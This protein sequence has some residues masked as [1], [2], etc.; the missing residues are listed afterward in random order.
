MPSIM[1]RSVKPLA[2]GLVAPVVLISVCGIFSAVGSGALALTNTFYLYLYCTLRG[3]SVVRS[4]KQYRVK[5]LFQYLLK[6]WLLF[7]S[8]FQLEMGLPCL[9]LSGSCA[10]AGRNKM[11]SVKGAASANSFITLTIA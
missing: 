10:N 6:H 4:P 2:P 7:V 5:A 8:R 3:Q 1:P 11:I 9:A